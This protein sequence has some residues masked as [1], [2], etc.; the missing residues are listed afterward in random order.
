MLTRMLPRGQ[1]HILD[2]CS[3]HL[4]EERPEHYF[5][6]VHGFLQQPEPGD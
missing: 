6:I 2:A 5:H 4:Q 3:H 1:L